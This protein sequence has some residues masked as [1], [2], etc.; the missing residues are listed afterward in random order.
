MPKKNSSWGENSKT[1]QARERKAAQKNDEQSKKKKAQEDAFWKDD[2]KLDNKKKERKENT[3]QKKQ[4]ALK[5]KEEAKKLLE[6]E[7]SKITSKKPPAATS[8]KKVTLSEIEKIKEKERKQQELL[9]K[10]KE[11]EQKKVAENPEME[12]ENPNVKMAQILAVEGAVE[13]RSA[14]EAIGVLSIDG[15]KDE[16]DRHPEKRMKAAYLEFEE[17]E[18]PKLNAEYSNMRLSQLKQMLRKEWQKSPD[19]PMNMR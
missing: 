1:V 13:A 17:R 14:T 6:E 3:E 8:T 11:K 19:N 5:R 12:E 9:A 4:E 7:E 2:N 18:L 15:G 10:E 16:V